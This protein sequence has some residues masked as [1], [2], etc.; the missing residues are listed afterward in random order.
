MKLLVAFAMCVRTPKILSYFADKRNYGNTLKWSVTGGTIVGSDTSNAIKVNWG[1]GT[2]GR[3]SLQMTSPFGCVGPIKE[4]P[5]NLIPAPDRPEINATD[6]VC[7]GKRY[8]YS[9]FQMNGNLTYTWEWE[10][11]ELLDLAN[12]KRYIDLAWLFL[13][14]DTARLIVYATNAQGCRSIAD[15]LFPVR[16]G[17]GIP[18][19][20]GP[21]AVCP[22]NDNIEYQITNFDAKTTYIWTALGARN[23]KPG[24]KG[25]A[26]VDWGNTGLGWLKVV[27]QNR[28]G[29]RD[30]VTLNIVKTHQL[31]GQMP[32]GDTAFCE[33]T[34]NIPYK[35]NAVSG[36]TY[37]WS[38]SGGSL[39]NGQNTPSITAN[40]GAKGNGYVGVKSTAYDPDK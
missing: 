2:L 38:I 35:V 8:K 25:L 30:S 28:F 1:N 31:P 17:T 37:S 11:A 20:S 21:K 32:Q 15:T 16:A 19:L 33:F 26:L 7:V 4:I 14:N 36:E 22:N 5:V 10:N 27:A 39:V 29:C 24:S 18:I 13:P 23:V 12:D 40:W 34:P 3:V 6:T 9:L